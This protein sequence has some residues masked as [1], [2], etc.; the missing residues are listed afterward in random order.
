MEFLNT[1]IDNLT[2]D[3]TLD[4]IEAL[5]D[6]GAGGYV[7]TPNVDHIVQLE[8][9]EKL[10]KAYQE[11]ALSLTDGQPLIWISKWLRCP[12]KEKISGSDLFPRLCELSVRKGYRMYFLGA[13][14]GVAELAAENL[15]KK[16]PGLQ[17]VGICAPEYGFE[18]NEAQK[19]KIWQ[20]I[21]KTQPQVLIVALGAPKQEIFLWEHRKELKGILA[22]GFG[23]CLDFEAGRIKRAP[24]WMQRSGME[25]FYRL[26]KEPR[27]LFKRYL[28]DDMKI[29][30]IVW[31]YRK[32]GRNENRN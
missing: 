17:I 8:T 21:H 32:V 24:R 11:A 7:V 3:E 30:P 26:C 20:D 15:K 27:R 10:R 2:F 13:A 16:Y 9:N 31:K 29:L 25:W 22:F 1:R 4:R 23:A 28:I 5:I 18:K 19:E 6:N 14:P 12:I